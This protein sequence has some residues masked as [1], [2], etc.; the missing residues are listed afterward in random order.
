MPGVPEPERL[1]LVK[2]LERLSGRGYEQILLLHAVELT[3]RVDAVPVAV[4]RVP[5]A[6][7]LDAVDV[8]HLRD[9]RLKP[10]RELRQVDVEACEHAVSRG[11]PA[12]VDYD[13]L[14]RNVLF[15][16]FFELL[17]DLRARDVGVERVPRAPAETVEEL[18]HM[19]LVS[20]R[21]AD[22]AALARVREVVVNGAVRL[23]R[24]GNR[25]EVACQSANSARV[26]GQRELSLAELA[27]EV[28][29]GQREQ[30]IVQSTRF[31]KQRLSARRESGEI[32]HKR[33]VHPPRSVVTAAEH[34]VRREV[35]KIHDYGVLRREAAGIPVSGVY[36]GV[37]RKD[38]SGLSDLRGY[39][40]RFETRRGR[41]GADYAS[42][43]LGLGE[44]GELSALAA[45]EVHAD[46]EV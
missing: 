17:V 23:G 42:V 15:L 29:S 38:D 44:L 16:E 43:L 45:D 3:L 21:H 39:C 2:R 13:P 9:G 34:C 6:D 10:L 20:E 8:L 24:C 36:A 19:S 32:L 18:G 25:E 37:D 27:A 11:H 1:V 31:Y 7:L 26:G 33:R 22:S 5:D 14:H 28:V 35:A 30:M 12:V 40:E 41:V 4:E 46:T